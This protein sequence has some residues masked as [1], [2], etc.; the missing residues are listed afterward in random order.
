MESARERGAVVEL[1]Q[2]PSFCAGQTGRIAAGAF[3][4]KLAL[5]QGMVPRDRC[6]AVVT[7]GRIAARDVAEGRS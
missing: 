2:A 6:G 5:Y 3:A 4:G 1:P 7:A